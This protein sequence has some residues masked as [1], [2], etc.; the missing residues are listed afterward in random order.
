[1]AHLTG[2]YLIDAPASALNNA[3]AVKEGRGDN[4]TAVKKIKTPMGALPYVSAQAQRYWLRTTLAD[5]KGWTASP[6]FREDKVA[7]TDAD[8][9]TYAEDDLFGYMRAGSKGTDSKTAAGRAAVSARGATAVDKDTTLTRVS[10]L[11]IGTAV[12]TAPTNITRDWGTMAR[13]QDGDPVPFEH[14]FYR[15]HLLAPWAIDLTAVGTFF[16]SKR[17]GSLNLDSVRIER[18]KEAKA[19]E[20][21]VRG[22]KAWRLPRDVRVARVASVLRALGRL[23]GGA[24]HTLHLTDTAPALCVFAVLDHGNQVFQRLVGSRDGEN[25][26]FRLDVLDEVLSVHG[27]SLRSDVY[28]GW[29]RG[30]LE[31]E[32]AALEAWLKDPSNLRGKRVHLGHPR[33]ML[34]AFVDE[35]LKPENDPWML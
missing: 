30:L 32:H 2:I 14:E 17:T 5:E 18:A 9:V 16:T 13:I 33:A 35:M 22:Q 15:A 10:P 27:D 29:A 21:E 6:V 28:I 4:V 34:G 31:G 3:G 20:V 1:M 12:A 11:K 24:K 26:C 7:Y 25:T 19:T 8:P 23:D